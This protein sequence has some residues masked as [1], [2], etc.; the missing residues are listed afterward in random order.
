MCFLY[1]S[2]DFVLLKSLTTHTNCLKEVIKMAM[3]NSSVV[4]ERAGPMKKRRQ[5]VLVSWEKI[6]KFL[7]KTKLPVKV[8]I[9]GKGGLVFIG[10]VHKVTGLILT[11]GTENDTLGKETFTAD[12][13]ESLT[14]LN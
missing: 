11:I 10:H 14:I 9:T 1:Y 12:Q 6:L 3:T 5:Q 2:I 4:F 8:K 13:F 7:A